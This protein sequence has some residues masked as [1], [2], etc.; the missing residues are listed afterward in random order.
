MPV[1]TKAP[2]QAFSYC[3]QSCPGVVT[4]MWSRPSIRETSRVFTRT[5]SPPPYPASR[6]FTA[7]LERLRACAQPGNWEGLREIRLF[8]SGILLRGD[9]IPFLRV[10]CLCGRQAPLTAEGLPATWF[11]HEHRPWVF[12]P[13]ENRSSLAEGSGSINYILLYLYLQYISDRR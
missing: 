10:D 5:K 3:A 7:C 6:P 2:F 4:F 11:R 8:G 9:A 1:R 13:V 12:F